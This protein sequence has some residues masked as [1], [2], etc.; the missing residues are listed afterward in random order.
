M[1]TIGSYVA[2]ALLSALA[3][4]AG[5]ARWIEPQNLL[6]ANFRGSGGSNINHGL[7]NEQ[8][9]EERRMA[10]KLT[11]ALTFVLISI[12]GGLAPADA[13]PWFKPALY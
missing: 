11:L 12:V 1:N 13:N 9:G 4:K 7:N 6:L 2:K 5:V 10:N 8:K 3:R